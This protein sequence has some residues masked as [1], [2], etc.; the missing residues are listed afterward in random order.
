MRSDDVDVQWADEIVRYNVN[1]IE[2]EGSAFYKLRS[3]IKLHG[4]RL[5]TSGAS[6]TI[7]T[8]PLRDKKNA[9]AGAS[10]VGRLTTGRQLFPALDGPHPI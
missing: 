8:S 3:E 6:K 2:I 9:S 5:A 1:G 7:H 10:R 4:L